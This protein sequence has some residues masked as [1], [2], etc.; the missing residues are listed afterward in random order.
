MWWIWLYNMEVQ[1]MG[2]MLRIVKMVCLAFGED[3]TTVVFEKK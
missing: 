2:F 1:N 3:P